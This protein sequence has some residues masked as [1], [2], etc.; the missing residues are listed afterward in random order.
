MPRFHWDER[1]S[2]AVGEL[3]GKEEQ[4]GGSSWKETPQG[5]PLK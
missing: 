3:P 4:E 1:A 5:L 2:V